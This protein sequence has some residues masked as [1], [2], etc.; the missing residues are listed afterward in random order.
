M[1]MR[2]QRG[3]P[4]LLAVKRADSVIKTSNLIINKRTI[5][6]LNGKDRLGSYATNTK[7][8]KAYHGM[9]TKANT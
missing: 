2:G 3:A 9:V 7:G 4:A 6:I 8:G 1:I 5:S